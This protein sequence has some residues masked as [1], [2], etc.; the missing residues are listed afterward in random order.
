VNAADGPVFD[1]VS[2]LLRAIKE[3]VSSIYWMAILGSVAFTCLYALH[4]LRTLGWICVAGFAC[5]LAFHLE[6]SIYGKRYFESLSGYGYRIENDELLKVD[7]DGDVVARIDLNGQFV[8]DIPYRGNGAGIVRVR[9][10]EETLEMPSTADGSEYI[11]RSVLGIRQ[12]PPDS[13]GTLPF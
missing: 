6:D 8:V 2:R 13:I 12:W 4:D 10:D 3:I 5:G 9:Q 1:R 11:A 7:I